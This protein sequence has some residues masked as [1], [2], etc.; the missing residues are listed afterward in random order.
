MHSFDK[1]S[2]EECSKACNNRFPVSLGLG[3]PFMHEL[4]CILCVDEE[5]NM[6]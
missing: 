4:F 2:F 3:I 5:I 6:E 1:S